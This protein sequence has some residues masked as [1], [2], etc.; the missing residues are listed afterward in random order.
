M[1]GGKQ[2]KGALGS[3]QLAAWKEAPGWG[4]G[5]RTWWSPRVSEWRRRVQSTEGT[6]WPEVTHR[7]PRREDPPRENP[8]TD[9]ASP[10]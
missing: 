7:M 6:G 10:L 9:T 8:K 4:V 1:K 5:S 2:V 3:P